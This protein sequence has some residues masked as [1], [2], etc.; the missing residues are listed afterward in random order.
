ML[1]LSYPVPHNV[2][3]RPVSGRVIRQNPVKRLHHKVAQ[4]RPKDRGKRR[5]SKHDANG[6]A[7]AINTPRL[8]KTRGTL[9]AR[10]VKLSKRRVKRRARQDNRVVL[11]PHNNVRLGPQI[12]RP[13]R[14]PGVEVEAAPPHCSA[15]RVVVRALVTAKQGIRRHK[16]RIELSVAKVETTTRASG[17]QSESSRQQKGSSRAREDGH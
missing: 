12:S 14:V 2:E 7:P 10:V 5:P 6:S 4:N 8:A 9:G 15:V 16:R 1:A 17:G 11:K 3:G 13:Q